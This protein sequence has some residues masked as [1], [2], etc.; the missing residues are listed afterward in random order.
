[1]KE[2]GHLKGQGIEGVIMLRQFGMA[3]TGF[4]WLRMVERIGLS[5]EWL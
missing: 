3:C 5:S 1:M 4:I 2:R